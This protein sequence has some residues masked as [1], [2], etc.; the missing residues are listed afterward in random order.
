M[1][2][3]MNRTILVLTLFAALAACDESKQQPAEAKPEPAA[4]SA[5]E[6]PPES[7][8]QTAPESRTEWGPI[9]A[10][11][12]SAVQKA[13]LEKA[14]GAR[15]R[16]AKQLV[17]ALGESVGERGFA[18]SVD[19]C[20]TVA[21]KMAT[22]VGTATGVSIGRTSHRLRNEANAAPTW[23]AAAVSAPAEAKVHTFAGPQGKLGLLSPIKTAALCTNCHGEPD[24]LADGVAA[25]L[26]EHYPDDEATGFAEGDLRGWFWVEVPGPS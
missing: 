23:A 10:A 14:E 22:E 9:A 26:H 17:G 2:K 4:E 24:S 8:P 5:P 16:L 15:D 13:Q 12:L 21:P 11:E 1:A 20:K 7:A 6:S 18:E 3:P 25:A 19:F